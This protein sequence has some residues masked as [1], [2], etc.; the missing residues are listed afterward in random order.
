EGTLLHIGI[1]EGETAKVDTLLAIIGKKD[2]DISDLI[3]G[4]SSDKKSEKDDSKKEEKS[5]DKKDDKVS[6]DKNEDLKDKDSDTEE[7]DSRL[8][9]NELPDGVEVITMPRLSDT[10]TEGTVAT[11]LKKEG[12]KVE[13]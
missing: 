6:D 3:D 10:M 1:K 5:S 2:E 8:H 9:G 7:G 13:E 11:W 12:D 4:K